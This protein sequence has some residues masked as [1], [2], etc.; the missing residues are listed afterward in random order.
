MLQAWEGLIRDPISI[1]IHFN[2]E[3]APQALRPE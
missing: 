2:V 3:A 1:D